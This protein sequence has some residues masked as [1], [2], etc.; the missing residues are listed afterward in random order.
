[1]AS[2]ADIT[3]RVAILK[4]ATKSAIEA[5][6]SLELASAATDVK[7]SQLSRCSSQNEADTLSLRDAVALDE[8]TMALGG[9]FIVRAMARVLNCAVVELP[10]VEMPATDLATTV[11]RLSAELGDLSRC[12][13]EA[14]A[15]GKV[16]PR[17]ASR[18]LDEVHHI[19]QVSAQLR[20]RLIA[21]RD[22]GAE[23]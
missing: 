23:R 7:K 2:K 15:D 11:V 9:P 16:T 4:V 17:E 22:G 10:D 5:M 14:L 1:M 6:R 12:I 18:A 20:L 19:N 8:A 3:P 21:I 13:A